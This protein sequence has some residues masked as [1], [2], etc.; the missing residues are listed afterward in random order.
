MR[1]FDVYRNPETEISGYAPYL[2]VLQ[3]HHLQVVNSVVV[4]P[5]INDSQRALSPVDIAVVFLG[6][7]FILA[8]A[9][10]AAMDG[11][12]L[13]QVIGSVEDQEDAIRRALD[14]IFTGF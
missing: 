9:E 13:Q 8:V 14:R 1:Q 7:P 2:A 3:S 5:R 4:A 6:S 11:R 10:M 12:R